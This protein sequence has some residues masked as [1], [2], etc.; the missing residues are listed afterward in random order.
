[1]DINFLFPFLF[2]LNPCFPLLSFFLLCLSFSFLSTVPFFPL[3]LSFSFP[4]LVF[5]FLMPFLSFPFNSFLPLLFAFFSAMP[6]LFFPSFDC[7][8]S[9]FSFLPSFTCLLSP[10]ASF[11]SFHQANASP[12]SKSS[13]SVFLFPFSPLDFPSTQ[14]LSQHSNQLL[15]S[16]HF[17]V[18]CFSFLSSYFGIPPVQ[19]P[20]FKSSPLSFL[21]FL[22][23]PLH[24]LQSYRHFPNIHINLLSPLLPFPS[25]HLVPFQYHSNKPT[26][27]QHPNKVP[28]AF[29]SFPSF[30]LALS[31]LSISFQSF[32]YP[33]NKQTLP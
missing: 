28:L 11:F 16:T 24:I 29:L 9:A 27:P 12:L 2:P 20:T 4:S 22:Y 21:S 26:L 15:C 10:M 23:P 1:M 7:L 33:S 6:F 8:L 17:R 30:T 3:C 5:L 31:L 32:Q 19:P 13:Y 14:T 25:F 18:I